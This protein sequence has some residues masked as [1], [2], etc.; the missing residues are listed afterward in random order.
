MGFAG[1]SVLGGRLHR[2]MRAA[3]PGCGDP[4]HIE[5][6]PDDHV[7]E[8][9]TRRYIWEQFEDLL[10]GSECLLTASNR[11]VT[12]G[13][14]DLRLATGLAGVEVADFDEEG[15]YRQPAGCCVSTV[16]H[17]FRRLV[18]DGNGQAENAVDA[19]V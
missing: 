12:Y 16:E 17:L 3:F 9:W 7:S 14:D 11:R 15:S 4:A 6:L 19:E 2:K 13:E 1:H 18:G 5:M 8:E 10:E